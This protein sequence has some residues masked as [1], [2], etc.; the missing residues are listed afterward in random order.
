MRRH[1]LN[2]SWSYRPKVNR[3][4]ELQGEGQ[5]W[6]P[7]TLPHDAMIGTDRAPD[8]GS[9]N[10]Y[11][12]GGTWEYRRTLTGPEA[13]ADRCVVLDFEGV[14]RDAAV[15]INGVTAAR[16]P[17]GYSRVAV[18]ID[19]LLEP[20][21]NELKVDATRS[22]DSRWYSGAGIHRDVWLLE[23]GRLHL[24]P[25]GLVVRT[26]E[27][28]DDGAV[29]TVDAVVEN[30]STATVRVVLRVEVFDTG[31]AAVAVDE[32]PLTALPGR[33]ATGAAAPVRGS[34]APVDPRG[35]APLLL[36][37]HRHRRGRRRRRRR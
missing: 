1:L 37:R 36:S 19:H 24:S 34:P 28:D 27:I 35:P 2:D 11:F 23:G 17:Y 31:G 15:I 10:V 22:A 25:G 12:E 5:E 7:V 20:G 13:G 14:Y 4:A 26:P 21:D 6:R 3:F 16:W 9:A 30:H 32:A 29:V 8:A 33:S 18:P